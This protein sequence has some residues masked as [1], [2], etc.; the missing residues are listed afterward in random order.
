[1]FF[2]AFRAGTHPNYSPVLFVTLQLC[3]MIYGPIGMATVKIS[4]S[5]VLLRRFGSRGRF[6]RARNFDG[7]FEL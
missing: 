3:V 5:K 7:E 1:M 4:A 2:N 6:F